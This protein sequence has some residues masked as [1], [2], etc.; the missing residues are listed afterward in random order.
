MEIVA[1]AN[2][3]Y[4]KKADATENV[5]HFT[6]SSVSKVEIKAVSKLTKEMSYECFTNGMDFER[7]LK[8]L[9]H[10]TK[11]H[12]NGSVFLVITQPPVNL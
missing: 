6:S 7:Y 11:I 5:E 1:I 2:Y 10:G 8:E 4:I 9:S 3:P 12:P